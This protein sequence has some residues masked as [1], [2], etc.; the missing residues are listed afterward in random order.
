M[1]RVWR[2]EGERGGNGGGL[3]AQEQDIAG[4]LRQ[5]GAGAHGDAGVGLGERGGVVDAVADHGDAQARLLQGANARQLA[6]GIES[7]FHLGDSGL[8]CDGSG[9][10]GRVAVSMRTRR[11]ARCE[12]GDGGGGVGAQRVAGVEI[13]DGLIVES[14]PEARDSRLGG[15]D[16]GGQRR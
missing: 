3:R 6:G 12:R 4:L 11:P 8:L 15:G 9:G 7:G 13:A 2:G 1:R 5:I 10:G 14:H 16:I